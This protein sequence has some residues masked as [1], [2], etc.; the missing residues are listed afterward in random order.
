MHTSKLLSSECVKEEKRKYHRPGDFHSTL[1]R[2]AR[3]WHDRT[4]QRRCWLRPMVPAVIC[5][6]AASP[7]AE[8]QRPH[9]IAPPR[10]PSPTPA[11]PPPYAL[12]L[13]GIKQPVEQPRRARWDLEPGRPWTRERRLQRR[14]GGHPAPWRILERGRARRERLSPPVNAAAA[15][16]VEVALAGLCALRLVL[17]HENWGS[18]SLGFVSFFAL[19]ISMTRL[20]AIRGLVHAVGRQHHTLLIHL[21]EGSS[22]L[23]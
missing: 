1:H 12:R 2:A 6:T 13:L 17:C 7:G 21:N 22:Y 16:C 14:R 11:S 4:R 8:A 10:L 3:C 23:V 15:A 9:A 19:L 5:R 20:T 18:S